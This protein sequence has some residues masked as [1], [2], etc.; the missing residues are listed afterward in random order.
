MKGD[1]RE[2]I[3]IAAG[4]LL[5]DILPLAGPA[6]AQRLPSNRIFSVIAA[7]DGT[8][9]IDASNGPASWKDNL[10]MGQRAAEQTRFARDSHDT[11]LQSF[12]SAQMK[13]Q[14]ATYLLDGHEDARRVMEGRDAV[15]ALPS[16]TLVTGDLALAIPAPVAYG[17]PRCAAAGCGKRKFMSAG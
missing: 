15:Q 3:A 1:A 9:W 10:R 16:S 5:A 6:F 13:F 7:N 14:A 2:T 17:K 11:M 4:S 12:Q 8:L